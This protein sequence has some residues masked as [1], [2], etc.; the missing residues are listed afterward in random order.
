MDTAKDERLASLAERSNVAQFVSFSP[1]QT[2]TMR[3]QRIRGL[4]TGTTFNDAR[5]VIDVLMR[6]SSGS[7]NIRSFRDGQDKG[8]PF[9][10]GLTTIDDVESAV[11]TLAADGYTTIVNETLDTRDGGVSGVLLRGVIEFMPFDTP[12]GVEK[13]GAASMPRKL[14]IDML[15]VVYGFRPEIASA[16]NE[17][18]EFSI[19]PARVGYRR[20]HTVLWETEQVSA[21]QLEP[22]IQWP[23]RFSRFIGDKAF[24]LLMAHLLGLP[25]PQTTVVARGVAPFQFGRRTGTSEYWMRT[26][27]VEQKPGKFPTT[28]GWQDPYALLTKIDPEDGAIASVLAQE[29][30]DPA[31]SGA[32]LPGET[33]DDDCI[34][35]VLGRGDEFMLGQQRPQAL[36]VEVV[37]DVRQLA[38]RARMALGP[39]RLE[40]VHDGQQAW[41]VQLHLSAR[42]HHK[43]VISPGRPKNGW[44]EFDPTAGLE[45][46][47]HLIDRAQLEHKGVRVTGPVGLTS[48]VGDLLRKAGIPAEL[49]VHAHL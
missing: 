8:N 38:G 14:G 4:S 7:L 46:L 25:V 42:H 12:R 18:I 34:E 10:Y 39:V 36:P 29:G 37:R 17:R 49:R 32:S 9:R 19:H 45:E 3:R 30:V 47:N 33:A 22:M 35:G 24:G 16:D 11:R 40:F 43:S 1:G 44:L 6:A 26:C 31:C 27:P 28:F 41:V 13:P 20:S 5:A 2:P 15:E 21:V 23:N 48:H